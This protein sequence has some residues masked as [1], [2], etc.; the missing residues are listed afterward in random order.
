MAR[1][2][3]DSAGSNSRGKR[4]GRGAGSRRGGGTRTGGKLNRERSLDDR[5]PDSVIEDTADL[6]S[7]CASPAEDDQINERRIDVPVAM[8]VRCFKPVYLDV[9][10]VFPPG[11]RSL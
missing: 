9:H 3:S 11:F 10:I 2:T 7:D 5:K 6:P 8:W 1:K 4:G